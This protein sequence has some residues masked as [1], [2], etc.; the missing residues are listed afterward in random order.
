M[1]S[2]FDKGGAAGGGGPGGAGAGDRRTAGPGGAAGGAGTGEPVV[3]IT[4]Y[5]PVEAEIILGKLHSADIEAYLRHEA[6][7]VVFGL[8]VDGMGQQDIMVRAE[9]LV[10]ARAALELEP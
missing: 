7:S 5:D 4:L 3:L 8:T 1:I 9:D 6:A 10:E 2:G